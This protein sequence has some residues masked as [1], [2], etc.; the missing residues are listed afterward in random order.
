MV[1]LFPISNILSA[2]N[3][4]SMLQVLHLYI[5]LRKGLIHW[6]YFRTSIIENWPEEQLIRSFLPDI[7]GKI[8]C[9]KKFIEHLRYK[10]KHMQSHY[11]KQFAS[12]NLAGL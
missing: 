5:D 10:L 7:L 9:K 12:S 3:Q 4:V 11:S 8:I 1:E 6:I 2:D